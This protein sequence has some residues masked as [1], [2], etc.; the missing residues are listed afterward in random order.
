[1]LPLTSTTLTTLSTST[2]HRDSAEK[3]ISSQANPTAVLDAL[4]S[5]LETDPDNPDRWCSKDRIRALVTLSNF[6][7]VDGI[8]ELVFRSFRNASETFEALLTTKLNANKEFGNKNQ[9]IL[10]PLVFEQ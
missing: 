10:S 3:L 1:M 5:V 8:R 6:A 7:V 2:A 9:I 4:V